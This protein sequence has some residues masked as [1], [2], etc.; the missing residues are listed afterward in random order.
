[1][2]VLHVTHQ[3]RPAVGGAEQYITDL[4]EELARRGH[5]ID[6]LT[7]RSVDYHTWRNVL[8][9]YEFLDGV[10]VHRFR[11][12]PRTRQVWRVLSYGLYHYWRTGSAWYEPLIFSGNGPVCPAMFV[13]IVRRARG[14]DLVHINNLHYSHALVAYAAARLCGLPV[15][16]TPHVHA[17][18]PE[19]HDVGYMRRI[20]RGCD[21]ILADTGAEK[22]YHTKRGWNEDVVL[23]GIGIR[24]ERFPPLGQSASRARFGLPEDGFV[25]L[26]L[27]RKTDYKGLDL[28]LKAFS[29]LRRTRPDVYLLAVGPET[30]FSRRLWSKH[31]GVNGLIVRDTVPNEE[32]LA[33]LA[34][35]DVLALPSTAEAFGIVYLEA[36]AYRKPVIGARIATAS[37][38]I[39][40]GEDGFLV[41]P[42]Q[43]APLAQTLAY[44]ADHPGTG[45]V[46]GERGWA[47]L[48]RRHTVGRVADVVEGTCARVLRRHRTVVG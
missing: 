22:Q 42:R 20:L 48:E 43:A 1:M 33:A 24:L 8:P 36:W 11:S 15:L 6:V 32:R 3:Y 38:I 31:A 37:S 41:E 44:L 29:L 12:L 30:E 26:F 21:A 2:R 18:Q 35:C 10:H 19:T 23:A 17:E 28:C 16:I 14:H 7:S 47:K 46:M 5:Q 9:A 25:I 27:G 45:R 39:R 34:A 4:S 40:D 13:E